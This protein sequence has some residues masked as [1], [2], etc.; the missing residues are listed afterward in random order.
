MIYCITCL[1]N[2]MKYV[3]QTNNLKRRIEHHKHE[4][5][6]VD[7]AI[8][9]YGWE[10][11]TVEVLEEC[12][13]RE[14]L[15]EREKFWITYFNCKHPNGYNLTDGGKGIIRYSH[16]PETCKKLSASKLG[17]KNPNFGKKASKETSAKLSASRKGKKRSQKCCSNI[18]AG[19]RGKTSYKNL[20]AE[21][22]KYQ[23]SYASLAKLMGLKASTISHKMLG[24]RNFTERDKAKLVEIFNKPAEYLMARDG[25]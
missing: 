16:T 9:K 1:L 25:K 10:T 8:K 15:N 11:F 22:T 19:K 2:Q 7:K 20:I 4:N 3:G 5:L 21:I 18:S 13:S 24:K 17:D 12:D 23:F 14:K 6:Y